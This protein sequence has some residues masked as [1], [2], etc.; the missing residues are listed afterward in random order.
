MHSIAPFVKGCKALREKHRTTFPAQRNAK[1][2]GVL[3]MTKSIVIQSPTNE[4]P[5]S[6]NRGVKQPKTVLNLDWLSATFPIR[7]VN[8][9]RFVHVWASEIMGIRNDIVKVA[10][11]RKGFRSAVQ[12]Q[13]GRLDLNDAAWDGYASFQ[14]TGQEL[15]A[16]RALGGESDGLLKRLLERGGHV[17][18][19]DVALDLFDDERATV[20]DLEQAYRDGQIKTRAKSSRLIEDMKTGGKTLYLG[21]RQSEVFFRGYDKAIESGNLDA[22]WVRLELEVKEKSAH[23][24]CQQICK[25]GLADSARWWFEKYKFQSPWYLDMLA[26]MNLSEPPP[27]LKT[28]TDYRLYLEGQVLPALRKLPELEPETIHWFLHAVNREFSAS[29]ETECQ[30]KLGEF[31]LFNDNLNRLVRFKVSSNSI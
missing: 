11:P 8:E 14:F 31:D 12:L 10:T 22:L 3:T 30:P 16:F 13:I 15:K 9:S 25:I 23:R 5:L 19:I 2:W 27:S 1:K 29:H 20:S 4:N 24:L 18:R 17:S 6:S 7:G 26:T 28:E 21:S